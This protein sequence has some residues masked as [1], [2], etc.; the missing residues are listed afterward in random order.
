M[1][2]LKLIL[3][4]LLILFQAT[5]LM[6]AARFV[7]PDDPR[8]QIMGSIDASD[9]KAPVFD[10]PAVN[11]RVTLKGPELAFLVE[12]SRGANYFNVFVDGKPVS[13]VAGKAGLNRIEVPGLGKGLSSVVLSKRTEGFQGPVVFKGLELGAESRLEEPLALPTRKIEVIG[14]SWACGYGNEGVT[15]GKCL[16][17]AAVSNAYLAFPVV[18]AQLLKAQYHV[19]AVSGRGILRN[20]GDKKAVSDDNMPNDFGRTLFS[21]PESKWDCSRWVPDVVIVRLGVNDYSTQPSPGEADFVKAYAAFLARLR[22]CYP[23]AEIFCFAD[24]GWPDYKPKI[25]KTIEE[26]SKKGDRRLHW[27]GNRGFSPSELGCDWHPSVKADQELAELLERNIRPVVG[28][29]DWTPPT[30]IP[31]EGPV[32][33]PPPPED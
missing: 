23:K 4:P 11:I 20:Y 31:T 28:W 17:L 29:N 19:T 12:D 21:R 27:V 15:Y 14:D 18:L 25:L 30:P 33:I 22:S 9:P 8:I 1:L 2:R 3:I 24:E 26:R 6:A 16:D 10:W 32:E 5:P 7:G 13:V